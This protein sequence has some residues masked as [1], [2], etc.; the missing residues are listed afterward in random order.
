[1]K[2]K[3]VRG[4]I[5]CEGRNQGLRGEI[6]GTRAKEENKRLRKEIKGADSAKGQHKFMRWKIKSER[7]GEITCTRGE[8]KV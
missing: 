7:E 6:K 4:E 3:C 8:I 2:I 1:M 5:T